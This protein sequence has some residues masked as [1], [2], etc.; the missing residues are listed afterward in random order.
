[1][2]GSLKGAVSGDRVGSALFQKTFYVATLYCI[3]FEDD[4]KDGAAALFCR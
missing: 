3:L 1:M 4:A 2:T